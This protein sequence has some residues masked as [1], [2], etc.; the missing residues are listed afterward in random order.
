MTTEGSPY[1]HHPPDA[2]FTRVHSEVTTCR[3]MTQAR[4]KFEW[5]IVETW[6]TTCGAPAPSRTVLGALVASR[7]HLSSAGVTAG[8][9]G[10]SNTYP[11]AHGKKTVRAHNKVTAACCSAGRCR[12]E[13]GS[14]GRHRLHAA[15]HLHDSSTAVVAAMDIRRHMAMAMIR[16]RSSLIINIPAHCVSRIIVGSH[17]RHRAA[18]HATF[19]RTAIAVI[20]GEMAATGAGV[21]PAMAAAH[22]P[23]TVHA[24]LAAVGQPTVA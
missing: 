22:F 16:A 10:E 24:F 11:R 4:S 6:Q 8:G 1:T 20:F 17:H 18:R 21:V 7:F 5:I 12:L 9:P 14:Q 19:S 15:H 2:V 3:H 13:D 23:R